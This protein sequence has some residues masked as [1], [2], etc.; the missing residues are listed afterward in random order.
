ML[1]FRFR[2]GGLI[3]TPIFACLLALGQQV[4]VNPANQT[5]PLP[6]APS[7]SIKPY[8]SITG[9][10]RLSWFLSS[11]VGPQTL[12]VGV[13]SSAIGTARDAPIEYGPHWD[14]FFERYG[15]RLTGVSTSNAME[16]GIEKRHLEEKDPRYFPSYRQPFR[17]VA[18]AT[19]W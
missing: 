9:R 2:L 16:A 19:L 4:E 18:C 3:L 12:A 1:T 5:A 15:M 7:A 17:R 11:T 10:Q 13:F 14:G 8:H 6:Q